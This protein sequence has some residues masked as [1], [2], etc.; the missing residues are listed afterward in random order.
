M[1]NKA[2]IFVNSVY[3]NFLEFLAKIYW[4]NFFPWAKKKKKMAVHEKPNRTSPRNRVGQ[5]ARSDR[6][7]RAPAADRPGFP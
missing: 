6:P 1:K 4:A 5:P 3:F 7:S 2:R